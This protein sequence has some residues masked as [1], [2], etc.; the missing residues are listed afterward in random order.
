MTAA[1]RPAGTLEQ[2]ILGCL[3]EADGPLSPR[4]VRERLGRDL[5]YTT[6]MTT[7]S[8]LHAKG[9]LTRRMAGR[10]FVYELPL[11]LDDIPAS[12]QAHRMRQILDSGEDRAG[13]LARFVTDLTP[14]DERVLL[15][16]LSEAD[17]ASED[18]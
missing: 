4:Q 17:A 6:V 13:I 11:A 10:G 1:R 8:R 9:V 3:A 7:L 18:D 2:D 15:R 16:L 12:V 14:E 5:A